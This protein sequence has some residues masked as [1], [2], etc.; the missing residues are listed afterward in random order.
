MRIRQKPIY[1]AFGLAVAIGLLTFLPSKP[2]VTVAFDRYENET[3]I[4]LC[5]NRTTNYL[6]CFWE[7]DKWQNEKPSPGFPTQGEAERGTFLRPGIS[8][9]RLNR[10]TPLH[11]EA[12]K[13]RV[14]V[15][16]PPSKPQ[17]TLWSA[18]ESHRS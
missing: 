7:G 3:A 1:I 10:T 6:V 16:M 4:L 14:L 18:I 15:F 2:E 17:L 12:H 9:L 13:L 5:N 8:S 11:P